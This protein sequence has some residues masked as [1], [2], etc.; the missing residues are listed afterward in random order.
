[1]RV[2]C[3]IVSLVLII[4]VLSVGCAGYSTLQRPESEN[5]IN[6][7]IDIVWGNLLKII[8]DERMKFK[9]VSKEDYSI[10][11][12][13]SVTWWSWGDEVRVKLEPKGRKRT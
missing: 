11:A 6:A 9:N 2:F 12:R 5:I 8:P 1:M 7:P 10:S 4:G 13:K 3:R